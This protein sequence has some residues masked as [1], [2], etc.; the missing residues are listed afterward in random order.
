MAILKYPQIINLPITEICDSKCIMCNVWKVGKVDQFT[1]E[2]IKKIFSQS[3]F[4][5]VIHIGISG[6]EPTLNEELVQICRTILDIIP[7]L[8]SLSITSNGY[9]LNKHLRI[10]PLI[11]NACSEKGVF[12]SINLS[13]DGYGD[14]HQKVRRIENAFEKVT[15]TAKLARDLDIHVQFQ[16]TI[17]PTNVYNIVQVR[18]YALSN[19]FEIIFRIASYI[20]RLSNYDL[21]DQIKLNDKQRSFVADFLEAPRTI[22][23]AHSLG[24]RLYYNDLAQRLKRDVKRKAPCS[25]QSNALYISPNKSIYNCSRSETKLEIE[26][27]KRIS[28]SINNKINQNIL[29]KLIEDTCSNCYHDQSGR[30][31]LF[32]YFTVLKIFIFYYNHLKKIIKIPEIIINSLIPIKGKPSSDFIINKVLIIGCYGGEHVGD[33]AILGGVI[34]RINKK[35]NAEKFDILSFRTDRTKCWINNLTFNDISLKVI[36]INEKIDPNNYDALVLA[37]GPLMSIPI[38]LSNHIKIIRAFKNNSLP[39]LIEGIGIGPLTDIFTI[40]MA[41]K[42]L[43]AADIVTIRTN[44]DLKSSIKFGIKGKKT[45]DPAFDYLNFVKNT[46]TSPHPTL[47]NLINTEKDLWIINLRPLWIKYSKRNSNLPEIEEKLLDCIAS[48]LFHFRENIRFIFMPMNADQFG[49]SD[50][51]IAYKLDCKLKLISRDIDF[52]IWEYEPDIKNCQLLL[53]NA[54]LTISMRFHGCVFSLA[55]N[56][57]TIGLDYSTS[58]KGKVY[59]LFEDFKLQDQVMNIKAIDSNS[60]IFMVN[61][62]LKK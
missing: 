14:M 33:A 54:K 59:S 22:L 37:G 56:I 10:L 17:T 9:H 42:I 61:K 45:C 62:L 3:F 18:E 36:G 47:E 7:K 46:E 12:F 1:A 34:L 26:N 52:K 5:K 21:T 50:L 27:I 48:T 28:D 60:M 38:L 41:K 15:S 43:N 44:I 4:K 11:K 2:S 32:R 51:E 25:F 29:Q 53:K 30:W 55:N 19:N 39:F 8:K 24:R 57:P 13:L 31:H 49:F 6:G 16:C 40:R 35:Y 23:A 58:E 20:A